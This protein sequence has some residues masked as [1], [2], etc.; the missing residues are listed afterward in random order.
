MRAIGDVA[1][2]IGGWQA[3][4]RVLWALAHPWFD[5]TAL[6]TLTRW[7]LP[8]SRAWAAAG[9]AGRSPERFRAE[10]PA[11]P[12]RPV[13]RVGL[14]RALERTAE[15]KARAEA[16]EAHWRSVFF[17]AGAVDQR[18]LF[19]AERRRRVANHAHM[20]ARSNFALFRLSTPYPAVRYGIP[21]PE[22][23]LAELAPL[24]AD[25]QRAYALPPTPVIETS[26]RLIGHGQVEY[27]LR[28]PSAHLDQGDVAWAR[29]QEPL[30]AADPPSLIH[31]HGLGVEFESLDGVEDELNPVAAMGIRVIRLEA[32]WHNRRGRPGFYGG[33]PFLSRQPVSG[34]E[35]FVSV[36]REV[37][38]LVEWCRRSSRGRVAIGGT[39]M[40]ALATQLAASRTAG[41][42]PQAVPDVLWLV[43]TSDD[44]GGL[45]FHSALARAAGLSQALERAGWTAD[46]MRTLQPIGEAVSAPA[47]APEDIVV[48]LGRRDNVTP[49][50]KG[51]AMVARWG[52]PRENVFHGAYGHFSVPIGLLGDHRPLRK[53]AERL[54]A[55]PK[56]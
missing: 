35:L 46:H 30:G 54:Q 16:A 4:R 37:G 36:A 38:A 45:A 23:G 1:R 19:Q 22:A 13:S 26:H 3:S 24:I 12:F 31:V 5:T 42:R 20:M 34:I 32:L 27:W 7:Y 9:V 50:A 28:F 52:V 8:L 40:G 21:S 53:L 33:E 51:A 25:P 43:T 49:Y 39:S 14:L 11:E 56:S 15:A 44:F 41:W 29:V 6:W 2:S 47:M 55:R 17:A 10:L 48:V 18:T